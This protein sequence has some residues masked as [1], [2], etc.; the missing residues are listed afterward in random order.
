MKTELLP[1]VDRV[2]DLAAI[3]GPGPVMLAGPEDHVAVLLRHVL[4]TGRVAA[5]L[6]PKYY[7][8]GV[9]VAVS[10]RP[11]D[12]PQ[13]HAS[14]PVHW[15]RRLRRP[16]VVTAAATGMALAAALTYLA[17]TAV[18]WIAAHIAVVLVVAA[19]LLVLAGAAGPRTCKT[20]ITI[21]HRH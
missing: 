1:R 2:E 7:N 3:R 14:P 19:A 21:I 13:Q 4:D 9:A 5:F 20:V 15:T 17:Y 16:V 18:A 10:L 6:P 8:G 11:L 12:V